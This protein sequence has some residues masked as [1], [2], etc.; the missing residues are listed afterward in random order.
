MLLL[1]S[2]LLGILTTI[3]FAAFVSGIV[4]LTIITV[5]TIGVWFIPI[6]M[7]AILFSGFWYAYFKNERPTV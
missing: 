5:N 7:T 1:K 4:F 3:G 6:A 2:I